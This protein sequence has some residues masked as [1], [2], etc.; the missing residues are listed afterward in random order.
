VRVGIDG[1][2]HAQ[3]ARLRPVLPRQVEPVRV[4][5]DLDAGAGRRGASMMASTSTS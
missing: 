2:A 1:R 4:R 3:F 5:I